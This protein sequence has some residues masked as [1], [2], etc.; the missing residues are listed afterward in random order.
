ME[1]TVNTVCS[2]EARQHWEHNHDLFELQRCLGLHV[3]HITRGTKE[4]DQRASWGGVYGGPFNN[5]D[6]K[7][8]D[9][10][11]PCVRMKNQSETRKNER[12]A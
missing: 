6:L 9:R 5:Q 4:P 7:M 3:T 10:N 1:N 2:A 8:K 12:A 11:V